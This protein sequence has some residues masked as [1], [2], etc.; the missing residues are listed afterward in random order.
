MNGCANTASVIIPVNPL[1]T[2]TTI[3]APS[4]GVIEGQ[5]MNISGA[6]K[7]GTAPYTFN[8]SNSD[9]SIATIVGNATAVFT[10]LKRGSVFVSYKV[11]DNNN[12]TSA[13]SAAI[14]LT[15]YPAVVTFDLPNAFTPNGDNLN[16]FFKV[17]YNHYVSSLKSFVIFN[18]AG[19]VVFPLSGQSIDMGWD[20]R[21]NGVMQEAD[22][23]LWKAVLVTNGVEEIKSGSVLLL[24]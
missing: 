9:P 17:V 16:D 7:I 14:T 13:E 15:V 2:I 4:A 5:T 10:G 19:R 6:V 22:A 1:P 18:R 3:V 8:W 21:V 11:T 20:G 23:Y 24:K 12:C